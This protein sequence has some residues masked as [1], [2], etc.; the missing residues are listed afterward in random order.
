M[1]KN[2]LLSPFTTCL[3]TW[4]LLL[5]SLVSD[6][7]EVE[8]HRDISYNAVD[9]L[10]IGLLNRFRA[11]IGQGSI[12]EDTFPQYCYH[13]YNPHNGR[14]FDLPCPGVVDWAN[15]IAD[16]SYDAMPLLWG[17]TVAAFNAGNLAGSS[18]A[19]HMLGRC[20]HLIQDMTS[21]AHT[22]SDT[23]IDGDDFEIWGDGN[24]RPLLDLEPV[25]PDDASPRAFVHDA[26]G[27]VYSRTTW[28]GRI[29]EGNPQPSSI[30][31][32][33]FPTLTFHDGGFLGDDYWVI[34]NVGEF[35][36]A[37][38][39]PPCIGSPSACDEW[40]PSDG[41]FSENENGPGGS[42]QIT[43]NFYI[44]NSAGDNNRLAP[45]VWNNSPNSR[46]LMSLYAEELYPV[47]ISHS[48]GL[49]KTFIDTVC[50]PPAADFTVANPAP[51]CAPHAVDFRDASQGESIDTWR[52]DFGDGS[53]STARNPVH[54]Y[55]AP[56]T[57]IVTLN[58]SGDCGDD[59]RV[60]RDLVR[61]LPG[62]PAFDEDGD[63]IAGEC[64]GEQ[65]FHRG[66][67]NADGSIDISD[68][69]RVFTFLFLGARAPTCLDA[70]DSNDD[71]NIDI[72]DGVFLLR[73]LFNGAAQPPA[74]GPP[75]SE[76]GNDPANGGDSLSCVSYD[77]C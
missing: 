24:F 27:F 44:E 72:T 45:A 41:D 18:G 7:H 59:T 14:G 73:Y 4:L 33:M 65:P 10:D 71:G 2:R 53:E 46:T 40:W 23:H 51:D 55:T 75:G 1:R 61:I 67:V 56:G 36:E 54:V 47:A 35:D 58:V 64:I 5:G 11:E 31:K 37:G 49:L 9:I 12:D 60:I 3:A 70:A 32:Q 77:S 76:C 38:L 6:G 17:Q 29:Y 42:R 68:P 21:P 39:F 26:A 25:F 74:P 50:P 48:A 62:T 15:I 34:D 52:W 66:D 63:R 43:G 20:I 57:Y 30:F 16:N 22:H 13:A 8:V 69:S 28:P 19:F